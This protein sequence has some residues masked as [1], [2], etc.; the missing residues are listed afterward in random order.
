MP[1]CPVALRIHSLI[2]VRLVLRQY[3][4][5]VESIISEQPVRLIQSVLTEQ[6]NRRIQRRECRVL[7][8]RYIR[9]VEHT[10]QIVSLIQSLGCVYE[11]VI[12][13]SAGSNY[14]LCALS[15]RGKCLSPVCISKHDREGRRG[16]TDVSFIRD[17]SICECLCC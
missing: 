14:H 9:G 11:R 2:E 1:H 8:D 16:S 5:S 10:L 15:R 13:L 17:H 6:W 12:R 7:V 3:L 4:L